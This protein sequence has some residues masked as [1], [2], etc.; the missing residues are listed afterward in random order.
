VSEPQRP[1]G[2]VAQTSP[3]FVPPRDPAPADGSNGILSRLPVW[4]PPLFFL[5][6]ATLFLWKSL[7][8]GEVF[9]P[10]ALLGHVQPWKAAAAYPQL[11]FWNPLRWDGIGQFYPWRHFA[12]SALRSGIIPLWNPYQ[13]C[14]TPFVANSQSAVLYPGNLLFWLL[15]DVAHAFGWSAALHLT[16]CGWFTYLLLR[17]MRCS[18]AAALLGGVIFAY[19]AWQA[20]WLQLPT[21]LATSCWFPLLLV[22]LQG[23]AP[24]DTTHGPDASDK[25]DGTDHPRK[26]P[27]TSAQSG[28]AGIARQVCGVAGCV[29]MMLLAG[30]LQ[31]ALYGLLAG[32]VFGAALVAAR[33]VAP[34]RAGAWCAG[35]ALGFAIALPQ[36]LPAVELSRMSHRVSKPTPAGYAAYTGYALPWAGLVQLAAPAFF[37]GDSDPDNPYWGYYRMRVAGGPEF[38][39][40]H[41]P[42]ETAIYVGTLPLILAL[43]ACARGLRRHGVDWRVAVFAAIG[44][45]ALLLALGTPVNALFYFTIPGFAQSGSPARCLVLWTLASAVLAALGLDQLAR[46]APTRRELAIVFGVLLGVIGISLNLAARSNAT[47]L[48]GLPKEMPVLGAVFAR[49]AMDWLRFALMLSAGAAVLAAGALRRRSPA[50]GL[51]IA[52]PCTLLLVAVDLFWAGA[53]AN[54]TARRDQV[55]PETNGIA[56]LRAHAGHDRIFPI[57]QRWSLFSAGPNF[58]LPAVLP[59][60]AATVFGLRDV[61]GYDSLFSGRYK[62]YANEFA[63]PNRIGVRDASPTEVG[64]IV[65]FQDANAPGARDS[66]AAFVVAMPADQPGAAPEALPPGV[67][68]DAEDAGM[69]ILEMPNAVGRARLAPQVPG[70]ALH[71]IEDGPTRVTLLV[72]TPSATS[73]DLADE[74][75]PG[76]RLRIDGRESPIGTSADDPAVRVAPLQA[77][78]H[79][80]AYRY[81]PASFRIGLFA[82]CAA[83]GAI[84]AA[85]TVA[86]LVGRTWPR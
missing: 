54:P 82:A 62:A 28:P 33:R 61:Q 24:L 18:E 31:I 70:G 21:F 34:G 14:G 27:A 12:A 6:L 36:V 68:L 59:P 44:L 72:D 1:A 8:T 60:N 16:L 67:P 45:L 77:G 78:R 71:W 51:P 85:L 79:V 39:V 42:A 57:N 35:L 76:W 29:A 73:L 23:R 4:A 48:A 20:A 63:R 13:F 30:H 19:S 25:A 49:T 65:F 37:G 84:A 81:E 7:F 52:L 66:G 22:A 26:T 15:P 86:A 58:N 83:L 11:P 2:D 50:L 10:A 41:N 17:R 46:L 38:A 53:G 69:R 56:Y 75:M 3:H 32:A 55:Y 40:P 9:L 74:A 80:V 64:N 43:L 5:L 47:V